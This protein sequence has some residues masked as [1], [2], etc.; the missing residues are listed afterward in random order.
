MKNFLKNLFTDIKKVRWNDTKS[1][2]KTFAITL[3]V[4][5]FFA[6]FVFF[7]TWGITAT[8]DALKG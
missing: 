4:V 7:V 6:L 2:L 1:T 8:M 5:A 3:L